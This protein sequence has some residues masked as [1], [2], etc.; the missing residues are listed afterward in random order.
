MLDKIGIEPLKATC[1][2]YKCIENKKFKNHVNSNM[3]FR[4]SLK[5]Y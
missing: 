3:R 2:L 4:Y 5:L 1:M